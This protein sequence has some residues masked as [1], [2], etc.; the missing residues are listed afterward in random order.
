[1]PQPLFRPSRVRRLRINARTVKR[2]ISKYNAHGPNI[3]RRTYKATLAID[4]LAGPDLT[5]GPE[6]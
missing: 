2:A 6:P 5:N 4:I 1:V 3:N